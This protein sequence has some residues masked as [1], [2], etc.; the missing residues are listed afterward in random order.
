M[1]ALKRL[2]IMIDPAYATRPRGG[3]CNFTPNNGYS[4]HLT[5][6]SNRIAIKYVKND[7]TDHQVGRNFNVVD[8]RDNL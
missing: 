7:G 8:A 1:D 6:H 3:K 5:I 2:Y 4:I